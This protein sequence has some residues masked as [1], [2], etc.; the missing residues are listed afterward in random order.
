MDFHN[1]S[2]DHFLSIS[3]Q[4]LALMQQIVEYHAPELRALVHKAHRSLRTQQ[5][6]NQSDNWHEEYSAQEQVTD[7][8]NLLELLAYEAHHEHEYDMQMTKFL[9]P[10]IE[11]IDHTTCD[12]ETVESCIEHATTQKSK[13]PHLNAQELLY[14]ELLKRWKPT[15]KAGIN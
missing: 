3:T 4:L 6:S 9:M 11:H 1:Q 15:K 14:K 10:A 7:F 13:N 12:P 5:P 8:L 2:D